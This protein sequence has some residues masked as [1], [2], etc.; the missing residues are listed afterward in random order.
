M[1]KKVP[2]LWRLGAAGALAVTAIGLLLSISAAAA[3]PSLVVEASDAEIGAAIHSTAELTEGPTATGEITFEVFGPGDLTCEGPAL[4]QS[5]AVVAGEGQYLSD[6]FEPPVAG[7]YHWTAR[8]S[9]DS[10]NEPGESICSAT[11]TV[12]KAS[13][14]L[15]G[16]ATSTVVVGNTITDQV[17]VSGGFQPGGEIVFRAYGPGDATCG[18]AAYEA[19]VPV[20]GNDSYSP[21]GF[22]PGPGLYRWTAEYAGDGNNEANALGCGADGQ[23]STVTKA[24]PGLA[25]SASSSTVGS[26]IHDEVTVIGGSSPGGEVSFSVYAP[27]DATCATPLATTSSALISGKATAADFSPQQAGAFRWSAS[28]EGDANNEPFDLD[29]EA[30][31]QTSTVSKASPGLSGAATSTVVVGNT[32]TDQVTVSGGFQP[33][34]EIVFRAYGPG[35]ATCGTTPA[36]EATEPVDGNGAYSPAGFAPG[37]GVYQW[38]ADYLGDTNNQTA[39]LAC[40]AAGQASAVGTIDVTLTASADEGTVG[41]PVT[42]T[43]TLKEGATP[44]GQIVFKAFPPADANC[45][46]AAAFSSTVG[47]SGNGSYK[48]QAFSPARSRSLPLDGCLHRGREPRA[49]CVQ[50]RKSKFGDLPG[51]ADH[52]RRG[53][54]TDHGRYR[55]HR[56]GDPARRL[57]PERLRHLPHLRPGQRRLRRTRLREHRSGQR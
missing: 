5:S 25:G 1:S 49:C 46:G 16:A 44:G 38:T 32:I 10:E 30:A 29:C 15:S 39:G 34:G 57:H 54:A 35:D 7:S 31:G 9:G 23:S 45:T 56:R 12:S 51:Q 13:P 14:G 55:L 19:T 24:S 33:G 37:P 4:S 2:G 11:S 18:T 27:S 50:L 28:Y 3:P 22:A 43:A 52:R 40:D 53:A 20:S 36:Y 17:T 6:D 48:S 21:A 42:A 41:T 47:V 8:Y 26:A